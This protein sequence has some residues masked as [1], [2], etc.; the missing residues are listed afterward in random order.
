LFLFT[1]EEKVKQK[2]EQACSE[3]QEK[4]LLSFGLSDYNTD[5]SVDMCAHPSGLQ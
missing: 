1:L 2:S 4:V 5:F 3:N